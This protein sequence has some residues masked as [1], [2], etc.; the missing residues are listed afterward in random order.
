MAGLACVAAALAHGAAPAIAAEACP[1][2]QLR[3]ESNVDPAPAAEGRHYSQLLPECRAYEM[4]SPLF[5]QSHD[6]GIKGGLFGGNN[7]NPAPIAVAPAGDAVRWVSQGDFGEPENYALDPTPEQPYVSRRHDE[8]GWTTSS[9]FAP[10]RLILEPEALGQFGDFSADLASHQLSCGWVNLAGNTRAEKYQA[11][12]CARR[13]GEGEWERSPLYTPIAG[14]VSAVDSSA[15]EGG[16]ADLSRAFLQVEEPL[17]SEDYVPNA[18]SGTAYSTAAIYEVSPVGTAAQ[19]RLVNIGHEGAEP[20]LL[21][22]RAPNEGEQETEPPLLGNGAAPTEYYYGSTYHAVSESGE[23]VFFVA[24]PEDSEK[25]TNRTAA[26]GAATAVYARIPCSSEFPTLPCEMAQRGGQMV[27]GRQT[28]KVSDPNEAEGCA[29]CA[30]PTAVGSAATTSGSVEVKA[31]G[32]FPGV[33]VGMEVS[34]PGIPSGTVVSS[35]TEGA[36]TLSKAATK[37]TESG[38]AVTLTFSPTVTNVTTTEKSATVSVSSGG[39]PGVKVGMEVKGPGIL[40]G[41]TVSSYVAGEDALTLSQ[42]AAAGGSVTLTFKTV[43]KP[44]VFQGAA[45]D[46]S[47]VFFTTAQRVLPP[48]GGSDSSNNLY[49]Y[50]FNRKGN[51][52]VDL[53]PDTSGS[54][55][56]LGVVRSSADGKHVYFIARGKLTSERPVSGEKEGEEAKEGAENLYGVN[57]ET[58]KVKFIATVSGVSYLAGAG[59]TFAQTTPDGRDLVFDSTAKLAGDTNPEP[60]NYLILSRKAL[61][62]KT[63]SLTFSTSTFSTTIPN[64]TEVLNS[65]EVSVPSGGFPGVTTGMAVSGEGIPPGT[66][67]SAPPGNPQAVYRYDFKTD[68]ERGEL[69][70]ISQ[71]SPELKAEREEQHA[72]PNPDEGLNAWVAPV[73]VGRFGAWASIDDESR[74]ISGE[75]SGG[76]DGE[77]VIFTTAERLQR[78]DESAGEQTQLY[79]WHCAAPCPHPNREGVV[80]MISDGRDGVEPRQQPAGL[81]A[82]EEPTTAISASG[83]DIF[84]S[85]RTRLVGQDGDELLDY[86]DAH[87]DGGY[88]APVEGGCAGEACQPT[89]SVSSLGSFGS[90]ASSVLGAGGNLTPPLG[91]ALAFHTALAKPT[92]A[93]KL[94]K[95]LKACRRQHKRRRRVACERRARKRYGHRVKANRRNAHGKQKMHRRGGK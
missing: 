19:L 88:P 40:S 16:S 72:T 74:A 33:K 89:R 76:H 53:S 24:T 69:T 1:N 5:K 46:G 78:G 3:M 51:R 20:S 2:E 56:V 94:A 38:K 50:D 52:V 6:V 21:V 13:E 25:E 79:L 54:A 39:F 18:R 77:D 44:V 15:Y 93:Q 64:V 42:A 9:V 41:T 23:T 80:R 71:A 95:A 58:D 66:T 11:T 22:R 29:A 8:A 67:V 83:S 85:T 90:A 84:F 60:L 31:S 17:V 63:V 81:Q 57:T 73:N 30:T 37:T 32:G 12:A 26:E 82:G 87:I 55:E 27:E 45:A 48:N 70:W 43:L 92:Q 47:K 65:N 28:V 4:V 86:Y 68:E 75:A 7:Y 61:A 36:V 49:E 14:A 59:K 62:S 91:S 10:Q 34:G 35:L